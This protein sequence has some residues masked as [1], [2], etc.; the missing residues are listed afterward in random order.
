MV[1]DTVSAIFNNWNIIVVFLS[2]CM[3]L[4]KVLSSS[5]EIMLGTSTILSI[6]RILEIHPVLHTPIS[7]RWLLLGSSSLTLGIKH[8]CGFVESFK[9]P[10]STL[11]DNIHYGTSLTKEHVLAT[12]RLRRWLIQFTCMAS[13]CA[14]LMSD[15]VP[16]SSDHVSRTMITL[17][18]GTIHR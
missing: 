10:E 5:N 14:C 11:N 1:L 15:E 7:A 4:F 12:E 3:S 6:A 18:S 13:S 16:L 2:T 8:C 17:F 9:Y